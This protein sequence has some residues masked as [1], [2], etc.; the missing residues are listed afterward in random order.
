METWTQIRWRG[1]VQVLTISG[2]MVGRFAGISANKYGAPERDETPAGGDSFRRVRF[3]VLS[4]VMPVVN[5]ACGQVPIPDDQKILRIALFGRLREVERAGDD[6]VGVDNPDLVV[7]N[8]MLG[9][10]QD[11]DSRMSKEVRYEST[12]STLRAYPNNPA[13][14]YVMMA[15]TR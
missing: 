14:R 7:G 11:P 4:V 2:I 1:V 8:C 13:Q 3:R 10:D 6:G 9:V 12:L 15:Q 5:V